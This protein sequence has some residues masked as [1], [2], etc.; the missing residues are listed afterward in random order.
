MDR[1]EEQLGSKDEL[2]VEEVERDE[3][4]PVPKS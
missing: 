2:M 4:F 1:I 3:Y